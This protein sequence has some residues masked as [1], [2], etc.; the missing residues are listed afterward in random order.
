M[1]LKFVRKGFKSG[2][3]KVIEMVQTEKEELVAGAVVK[4][5]VDEPVL[6]LLKPSDLGKSFEFKNEA[7]VLANYPVLFEKA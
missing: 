1:A 7:A 6:L 5:L 2:V 3:C 4:K